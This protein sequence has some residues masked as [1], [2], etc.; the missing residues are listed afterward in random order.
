MRTSIRFFGS[1]AALA[2]G[3]LSLYPAPLAA[4]TPNTPTPPA[5]DPLRWPEAQRAFYQ[6]GPGLL[7]SKDQR[8]ALVA[9]DEAGREAAIRQFLDRDPLPE[10]PANELKVGIEH[11]QQLAEADYLSPRDVR[12]QLV[13]LNGRPAERQVID[14][15]IAFKPMEIWTYR[16]EADE[17]GSRPQGRLVVYRAAAGEPWKLWQRGDS[18]ELLYTSEMTYWL[19]QWEELGGWG[20][21]KRFDLQVCKQADLI[22][23]VTGIPGLTGGAR[24]RREKRAGIL[25]PVSKDYDIRPGTAGTDIES[26]IDPPRDLAR[27]SRE[28][29][30]TPMPTTPAG[31]KPL[32]VGEVE[33]QF[34]DRAGQ[35]ILARMLLRV[36]VPKE[37]AVVPED[38]GAPQVTLVVDGVVESEGRAFDDF[39]LR[40]R[41][42]PRDGLVDLAVDQPL[43][44]ERA[45]L[46]RLRIHDEATGA[47]ARVA[48]GFVVP[49]EPIAPTIVRPAAVAT[50]ATGDTVAGAGAAP[51]DVPG[52]LASGADTVT[53]LPPEGDISLGLWRAEALTT[54]KR[55]AK[56]IFLVDGQQ[57]LVRSR[58]P[59]TAEL[60]LSK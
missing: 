36:K 22:D 12:A 45:F 5:L 29:A 14:C 21:A 50:D 18:K 46:I 55:I 28:A 31:P 53:L 27:W 25:Q 42:P 3:L 24:R 8:A 2:L 57:Q 1:A 33:V 10:T 48:R 51:G 19:Q 40:F 23:K 30:A 20:I 11:R 39:R 43:R 56:V 37:S 26:F 47:E 7:L 35:R 17:Q 54:G 6:D 13:F 4:Q 44:P 34:P 9:E 58:A 59:F 49:A 38:G 32:D 60:R 52:S 41:T 15:G 16:G